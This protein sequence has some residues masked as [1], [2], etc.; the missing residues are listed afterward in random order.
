[1]PPGRLHEVAAAPDVLHVEG[2]ASQTSPQACQV[3]PQGAVVGPVL[4][5]GR[6]GEL[7]T[8][9]DLTEALGQHA[10]QAVLD[11]R[12]GDPVAV[13]AEASVLADAWPTVVLGRPGR[14]GE[15]AG[16]HVAVIGREADPV[17]LAVV[18]LRRR[19]RRTD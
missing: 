4:R 10:R 11:R 13:E 19:F 18:D 5:P 16:P 2:Y 6:F 14:E 1:R 7:L 8:L 12:E 15:D 17:L 9:D 3:H